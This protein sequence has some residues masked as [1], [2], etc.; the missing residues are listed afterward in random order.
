MGLSHT[1]YQIPETGFPD[2]FPVRGPALDFL[3]F[4]VDNAKDKKLSVSSS[5]PCESLSAIICFSRV[6]NSI[7]SLS[8]HA[9][10]AAS[11]SSCGFKSGNVH[12]E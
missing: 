9:I 7:S 1:G 10:N 11:G 5:K 2:D 12:L 3:R 8:T 6:R 4:R